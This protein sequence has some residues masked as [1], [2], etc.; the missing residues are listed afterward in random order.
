MKQ[1]TQLFLDPGAVGQ[2]LK[3]RGEEVVDEDQRCRAIFDGRA[4][5]CG[6]VVRLVRNATDIV[7]NVSTGH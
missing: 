2:T 7:R 3:R 6:P 5:L 4:W 1:I